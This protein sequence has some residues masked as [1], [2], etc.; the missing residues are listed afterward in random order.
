MAMRVNTLEKW[1]QEHQ[2]LLKY[3]LEGITHCDFSKQQQ[4]YSYVPG[5][6]LIKT[7]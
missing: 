1:E 3:N 7:F 4:K 2:Q 6:L 5:Y